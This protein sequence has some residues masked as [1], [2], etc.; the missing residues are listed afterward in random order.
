MNNNNKSS[1]A[2]SSMAANNS[3]AG[4]SS[5]KK[6][7]KPYTITKSRESWTEEEHDKFLEA[8]QLFDRDWKKIEDFVGSK[9]VIQIRSHAQK[10]FLKV[11]KNGSIAHVP[12]P[13]PKRKATHPYPQKAPK[14]VLLPLQASMCYPS[15]MCALAPGYV[16]SDDTSL[17]ISPSGGS[18]PSQDEFDLHGI[19]A[20]TGSKGV[21]N[22]TNMS[23]SGIGMSSREMPTSDLTKQGEQGPVVHGIP[24]FSEVY[25]FIGSVFDPHTKGHVQKLKEMDPINFETVLLLMRNLTVNLSSPDF[26]PMRKVL[27]SYDTN[28]K[29]IGV[30][31]DNPYEQS[32]Q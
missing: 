16:P 2:H 31:A 6:V 26:E 11:Q 25:S 20:D 13:R 12:P 18:M 21:I 19:E 9:T 30:S 8:L 7:R 24:D 3:T 14:N 32:E 15:S 22:I 29:T 4:D 27:S 1:A 17:L 5:G 28:S 23:N 10:Y